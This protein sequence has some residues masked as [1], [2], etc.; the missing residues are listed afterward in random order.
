MTVGRESSSIIWSIVDG[1]ALLLD[2]SSGHYFSM[3][4]LAT[5]IWEQLHRKASIAQIV[6]TISARYGVSADMVRQDVVEL[7][8]ELREASLWDD[9]DQTGIT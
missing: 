2:S 9:A 6:E 1:E 8:D 3:N 4:P 7:V 5:E